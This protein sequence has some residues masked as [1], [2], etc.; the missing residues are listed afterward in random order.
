MSVQFI[1]RSLLVTAVMFLFIGLSAPVIQPVL[2]QSS[3]GD[4]LRQ[5]LE[6]RDADIKQLLS[7]SATD[8]SAR[9]ELKVV[10]NDIIDFREMG[11][12]ALGEHW[13]TISEVQRDSFVTVF[14]QIVREQSISNLDIYRSKITYDKIDASAD[15]ATV[16]TSTVYKD[17]PA[18]VVYHLHKGEQ[19]DGEWMAYDF[20][21]DDVSTVEGY[22]KSFQTVIRKRGFDKL[23]ESLEKKRA[24][25]AK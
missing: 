17:V 19:T 7:K 22:A 15:T 2:G 11:R 4:E 24:Q 8:D 6:A 18:T 3:H 21:L 14:S 25:M 9:D 16:V 10:I 23:M 1:T 12:I 20:V 13:K 5:L